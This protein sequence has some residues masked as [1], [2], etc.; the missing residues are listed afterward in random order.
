MHHAPSVNYPVERSR[1]AA[2]LLLLAWLLGTGACW[3]WWIQAQAPGWRLGVAS[4]VMFATGSFAAWSWWRSPRGTLACDGE[5]WTW[6]ADG[7]VSGGTP[8]VSLD[9][10]RWLLLHWKG[11]TVSRWLWLVRAGESGRWDDLRRA[12]YSRPRP[13]AT[14]EAEPFLPKP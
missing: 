11:A 14:P 2:A 10:Q 5:S 4:L 12:V 9:L 7:R 13:Q 6:L 1:F 3:L 8:E